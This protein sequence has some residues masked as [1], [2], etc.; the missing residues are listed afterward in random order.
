MMTMLLQLRKDHDWMQSEVAGWVKMPQPT[1]AVAEKGERMPSPEAIERL[2]DL[3]GYQLGDFYVIIYEDYQK[4]KG[5]SLDEMENISILWEKMKSAEE[6]TIANFLFLNSIEYKYESNYIVNT[7]SSEF[8]QYRPDFF[9]PEYNIYIEHFWIDKNGNVPKFFWNGTKEDYS[10]TNK[11][12]KDGI[13]WKK[14]LHKKYKTHFISTYSYEHYND[15]LFKNLKQSLLSYGVIF[16]KISPQE[17]KEKI[18]D[19]IVTESSI[20]NSLILTFLSLYKSSN[21]DIQT[22]LQRR[23]VIFTTKYKK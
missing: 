11:K 14:E 19:K 5:A 1:Y 4:Y 2:A 3:Y 22:L 7:A 20:F 10:T 15:I 16:K 21:L 17:L 8:W 9:L 12:Y 6:V 18:T 23:E 13:K